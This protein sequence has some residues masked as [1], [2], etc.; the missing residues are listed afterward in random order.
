MDIDQKV[1]RRDLSINLSRRLMKFLNLPSYSTT[2]RL[3]KVAQQKKQSIFL[4]A[5]NFKN[6]VHYPQNSEAQTDKIKT[7]YR[8]RNRICVYRWKANTVVL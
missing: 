5:T 3:T 4:S 6:R 1:K 8:Y 7:I 2:P